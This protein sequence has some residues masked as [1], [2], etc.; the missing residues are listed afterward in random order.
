MSGDGI[1][2]PQGEGRRD[3]PLSH[4]E[5]LAD[6]PFIK[7]KRPDSQRVRALRRDS[8]TARVAGGRASTVGYGHTT[9]LRERRLH[10][11]WRSRRSFA[12]PR[13]R[14]APPPPRHRRES[15]PH[16]LRLAAC[17][18][19]R[20]RRRVRGGG[21]GGRDRARD[22]PRL[23]RPGQLRRRLA[24]A[25]PARARRDRG[26]GAGRDRGGP[27]GALRQR[28]DPGARHSRSHGTGT[29]EREPDRSPGH[30]AQA[31][32][33]GGGDRHR[34]S[35][36]R[37]GAD[38]RDRRRARLPAGPAGEDHRRRAEDP[39]GGGS[40]GRDGGGVQHAGRRGAARDRAAA[41]RV[42]ARSLVPV[43][44]AS[45]AAT[46]IRMSLHGGTPVFPM[47]DIAQ[48]GALAIVAYIILGGVIG[49][50]AAGITR[51]VYRLEDAFERLPIHWMWWPA[52]G[53][54]AV[55]VIGYI[56]PRT[57]GV[58]YD[59]IQD[60]LTGSL[61]CTVLLSL[62]LLKLISWAVALSSGTS[63]GTLAPLF[64]IGGGLGSLIAAGAMALVPGLG[65]DIRVAGLV[66]MAAM[67]AGASRA[68]LASIVFA[69]E[70]TR[71]PMGL[72][73]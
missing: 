38:H 31:A 15:R 41:V 7:P 9:R 49:L 48:P 63:G 52:I 26:A 59:N 73:P 61:D 32:L 69:F 3:E 6:G 54:V 17:G 8:V 19:R 56:N 37:R 1:A 55:G 4:M 34:R 43:A 16:R 27:H 39:A 50:L 20:H 12:R 35:L 29:Q 64:T 62:V 66:G 14:A 53:A 2:A 40:G 13:A 51:S 33:G 58:G 47:A 71:Q 36:R 57:L 45:S 72:L 30:A 5:C 24:G 60:I 68:L 28:R 18:R 11:R 42:S 10:R 25:Q 46:A 65:M 67:F 44:L 70:T 22:Q 21:A 23:L